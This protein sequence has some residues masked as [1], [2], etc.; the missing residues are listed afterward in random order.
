MF[1]PDRWRLLLV[2]GNPLGSFIR[3]TLLREKK[4]GPQ[5]TWINAR[6]KLI[7]RKTKLMVPRTSIQFV[8]YEDFPT[9]SFS[10]EN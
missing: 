3:N 9:R 8:R 10:P 5:N 2:L 4:V 7:L 6:I 1:H